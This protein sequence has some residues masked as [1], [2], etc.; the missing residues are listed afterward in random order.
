MEVS[1]ICQ[2]FGVFFLVLWQ[3][4]TV[5]AANQLPRE[6]QILISSVIAAVLVSI[7]IVVLI[8]CCRRVRRL[9]KK[10]GHYHQVH[11]TS[12]LQ[13]L[14]PVSK[15]TPETFITNGY[16]NGKII[17]GSG[18]NKIGRSHSDVIDQ[19]LYVVPEWRRQQNMRNG[20]YVSPVHRSASNA[21]ATSGGIWT[22]NPTLTQGMY[23]PYVVVTSPG[24]NKGHTRFGSAP[25][26]PETLIETQTLE[27]SSKTHQ[28]AKNDLA[29]VEEDTK[30]L[31]P[32]S[33]S[34][35][36]NSD[37]DHQIVAR[38]YS[39]AAY[40]KEQDEC[41]PVS[42]SVDHESPFVA[43][44]YS[45]YQLPKDYIRPPHGSQEHHT[46]VAKAFSSSMADTKTDK[47]VSD[48]KRH[49][50]SPTKLAGVH[51]ARVVVRHSSSFDSNG[52]PR[53]A[54]PQDALDVVTYNDDGTAQRK[55]DHKQ[56][57]RSQ[58]GKEKK[59]LY[60]PAASNGHKTKKARQSSRKVMASKSGKR[61]SF[62]VSQSS[63]EID[64]Y[65]H[66]SNE[67]V[68]YMTG[69]SSSRL[70]PTPDK[71]STHGN[72]S[73]QSRQINT[74]KKTKGASSTDKSKRVEE[75]SGSGGAPKNINNLVLNLDAVHRVEARPN[76]ILQF[77]STSTGSTG[78]CSSE[79]RGS[80]EPR[81]DHSDSCSFVEPISESSSIRR[82]VVLHTNDGE[83]SIGAVPAG[84]Q[85]D[86]NAIYSA[87]IKRERKTSGDRSKP[88]VTD[89]P[90]TPM[91]PPVP[92]ITELREEPLTPAPPPVPPISE[93]RREEPL[94]PAPPPVPPITKLREEPLT[95]LSPVILSVGDPSTD[96]SPTRL[97]TTGLP[98]DPP[99]PLPSPLGI[100]KNR[101]NNDGD[102][103]STGR[104]VAKAF[105]FLETYTV[106][107]RD[108]PEDNASVIT[109]ATGREGK[110]VIGDA[111]KFLE[112]F[113]DMS[114]D[115]EDRL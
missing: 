25:N 73:K 95:P 50:S 35:D 98:D 79:R 72:A 112:D 29:R 11:E 83:K 54:R 115:A 8:I 69:G 111:F 47:K 105:E 19:R 74:K 1:V 15:P 67:D 90:G 104:H 24:N 53:Y 55:K 46:I 114:L 66:N 17:N 28:P 89:S 38:A 92:P 80:T 62:N 113:D 10:K 63:T 23:Q 27:K 39:N 51:V 76:D 71:H 31:L 86:Q 13:S 32:T 78:E 100:I 9:K 60:Q 6:T 81:S 30:E 12:T 99:S 64:G 109:S 49:R 5:A 16:S 33:S 70:I 45:D 91:P 36:T 3:S 52:E 59:K 56:I 22:S 85:D 108:D 58:S 101:H 97:P 21:S 26:L 68:I 7:A 84:V 4:D 107:S 65:I 43:K 20:S 102:G 34:E 41:D 77:A 37:K 2:G 106:T 96:A 87:P 57:G 42:R 93:L 110:S 14:Y 61:G 44:V 48:I 94:M 88:S 40:Q 18:H 103:I 75:N 82:V